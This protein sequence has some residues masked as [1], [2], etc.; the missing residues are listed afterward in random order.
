ME[1]YAVFGNPILHSKSPQL[2]NVVFQ[3]QGINS[4]YTRIRPKNV[5]DL[6][7]ITKKISIRGANITTP[8]KNEVID[9]LDGLSNEAKIINGVNCIVSNGDAIIGHNT[10]HTGAVQSLVEVGIDAKGKNVLVLG[11]GPAAS[12]AAFGLRNVGA[13]IYISNRTKEKAIE[14]GKRLDVGYIYLPEIRNRIGSFDIVVSALLPDANPLAGI[15]IPNHLVLLDANYRPSALSQYMKNF[16]CN[17]ISGKRWLI[18]QAI[19]SFQIFTKTTPDI[20][21]MN[22][23]I[24]TE[25]NKNTLKALWI[26]QLFHNQNP[27]GYDI[28]ISAGNENEFMQILDEEISKAFGS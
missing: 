24:N 14:I 27:E 8:F 6:V 4:Y 20:D 1:T 13:N 18:H 22:I 11:A 7:D 25:L 23:A 21:V 9:Y 3:K 26:E 28:L 2:F 12:A 10:D 16:G 17:L 19:A 15:S 5:R